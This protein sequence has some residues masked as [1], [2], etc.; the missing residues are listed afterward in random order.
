MPLTPKGQM[1]IFEFWSG[2]HFLDLQP[3]SL[4]FLEL[5]RLFE[6]YPDMY[7]F[8]SKLHVDLEISG[9]KGQK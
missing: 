2:S 7:F 1:V 4:L 9:C 6:I 5:K 8:F 3:I